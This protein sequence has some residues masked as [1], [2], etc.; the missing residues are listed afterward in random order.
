[1]LE[2]QYGLPLKELLH[3]HII[4]PL[5]MKDTSLNPDGNLNRCIQSEPGVPVGQINDPTARIAYETDGRF[6]GSAGVFSTAR[7]LLN[8]LDVIVHRGICNPHLTRGL[9]AK[10]QFL[11]TETARSLHVG[12]TPIF[13]NGVGK[14]NVFRE[15][16]E[17]HTPPVDTGIHKLGHTGCII[18]V[19]PEYGVACTVLTDFLNT[20]RTAE[21]LRLARCE[22]NILFA[23]IGRCA[24]EACVDKRQDPVKAFKS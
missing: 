21:E 5:G 6:L 24:V 17:M 10:M 15:N 16:L 1:M 4:V 18:V 13:G 11:D 22:L 14:W 7:D 8:L 2:K 19:F 23:E 3:R 9:H 12:K 20:P